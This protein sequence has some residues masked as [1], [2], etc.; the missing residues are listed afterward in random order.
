MLRH[1]NA[2]ELH[3]LS[4]YREVEQDFTFLADSD[5]GD[6]AVFGERVAGCAAAEQPTGRLLDGDQVRLAPS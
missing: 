1:G 6:L 3:E 2:T 5:Q 4:P